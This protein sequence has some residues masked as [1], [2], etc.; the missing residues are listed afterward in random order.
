MGVKRRYF[1]NISRSHFWKILNFDYFCWFF[2]NSNQ[3]PSDCEAN[4]LSIG[5]QRLENWASTEFMYLN[6]IAKLQFGTTEIS[7]FIAQ[8]NVPIPN[9]RKERGKILCKRI[10]FFSFLRSYGSPLIPLKISPKFINL[11]LFPFQKRGVIVLQLTCQ[12]ID[13]VI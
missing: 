6:P 3:V 11:H 4:A 9:S 5:P 10:C 7:H 2:Q 13:G 12:K 8:L 1:G